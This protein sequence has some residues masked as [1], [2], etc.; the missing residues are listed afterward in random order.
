MSEGCV[1]LW[2]KN[3]KET[4]RKYSIQ[5][6]Y[7]YNMYAL[8]SY[9][10]YVDTPGTYGLFWANW[11]GYN[12]PDSHGTGYSFN[13]SNGAFSLTGV[14]R[15]GMH[16]WS[17]YGITC[18][19][20][21]G[22]LYTGVYIGTTQIWATPSQTREVMAAYG[23]PHSAVAATGYRAGNLVSSTWAIYGSLPENGAQ[24]GYWYTRTNS[25][26]QTAGAFIGEV[27][28]KPDTYPDNGIKD[29]YWW[30]KV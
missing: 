5:T 10:Y 13:S 14:G 12:D 8:Q 3:N 22:I 17:S 1:P 29:G 18:C 21:N 6:L 27:K 16:A 24:G 25:S 26:T 9:T 19:F 23:T 7:L 11:S 2:N 15:Y 28:D 4:W 30:I 20:C